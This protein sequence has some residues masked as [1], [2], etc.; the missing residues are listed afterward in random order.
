[1][2]ANP[3]REAQKLYTW[4][5]GNAS[6]IASVEAAFDACMTGG[7]LTRGGTDSLISAGKNGVNMQKVIGLTEPQRS[8]AIEIAVI[9]LRANTYPST[10]THA[11]F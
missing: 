4:A 2:A 3:Q 11:R 5:H 1:M 8:D 6:R 10:R 7:V 9:H